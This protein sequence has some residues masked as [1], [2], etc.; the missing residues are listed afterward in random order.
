M[1]MSAVNAN[2]IADSETFRYP[3]FMFFEAIN[4]HSPGNRLNTL[5]R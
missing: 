5:I 4:A 2:G 1:G 3:R